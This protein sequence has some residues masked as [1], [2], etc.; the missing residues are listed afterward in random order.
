VWGGVAALFAGSLLAPVDLTG[1]AALLAALAVA[2]HAT[3][4]SRLGAPERFLWL[5]IAG[6]AT[7]VLLPEVVYVRDAFDGGPL[8]RMNTVFKLSYQA[9]LLLAVAAACALPWAG[10]WL[11]RRAWGPWAVVA[12]VLLLLSLVYP[13]AGTYAR[14]A[15]FSRS[16]TLDGLGWLHERAPGDV[17]AIAWLREHA[18]GDAVVLEAV[19]DDYSAFGHARISTF[20]GRPT[21][22]GW[23]GHE[24]QWEHDPGSRRAEVD[25]LYTT[26]NLADARALLRRYRVRYVVAGPIERADYGD[27]GLAKWDTLARRVFDRDGTT[28]WALR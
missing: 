5:L 20:T 22:M 18:A 4:R 26:T 19:G 25:R 6:G 8:Y 7:C 1:V 13:Y 21:V 17:A 15:G 24:L 23:A 3:F 2:L 10:L 16:P 11:P 12:T 14:H 28:V 9:W 27:A